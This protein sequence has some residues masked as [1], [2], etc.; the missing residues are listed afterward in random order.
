MDFMFDQFVE[1]E[2]PDGNKHYIS[3]AN[4]IAIHP[5]E[6]DV[7]DVRLS[8]G[9]VLVACQMPAR[10]LVQKIALRRQEALKMLSAA[11]L[12]N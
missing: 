10:V 6:V 5:R 3:M 2:A 1:L 7:C 11:V 12:K 4:V 8:D 9:A